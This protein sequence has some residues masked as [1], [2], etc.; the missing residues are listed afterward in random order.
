M[1]WASNP[2][3]VLRNR[4]INRDEKDFERFL[5]NNKTDRQLWVISQQWKD[6]LWHED[7]EIQAEINKGNTVSIMQDY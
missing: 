5:L 1:M 3:S 2:Q 4:S 6:R 7:P